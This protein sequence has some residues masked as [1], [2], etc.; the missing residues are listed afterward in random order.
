[1]ESANFLKKVGQKLQKLALLVFENSRY[2]QEN[3]LSQILT[4]VLSTFSKVVGC[5]GKAP[6]GVE[7]QRPS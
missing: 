2:F 1:L 3:L 5:R 4:K 7:G 6:A